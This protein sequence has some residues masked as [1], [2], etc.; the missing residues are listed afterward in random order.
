MTRGSRAAGGACEPLTWLNVTSREPQNLFIA[1]DEI[2]RQ[3]TIE[4]ACQKGGTGRT[5]TLVNAGAEAARV[6]AKVLFMDLDPNRVLTE[7]HLGFDPEGVQTVEDLILTARDGSAADVLLEAPAPWQPRKDLDYEQGGAIPGTDGAIAFIPAS[8]SLGA[9]AEQIGT[10]A[11][12]SEE[13]LAR[14]LE[15]V[16]RH[17]D[18]VLLDTGPFATRLAWLA[19]EAAATTICTFTPEDGPVK[20]LQNQIALMQEYANMKRRLPLRFGGAI[21]TKFDNRYQRQH[22]DG[23]DK[24]AAVLRDVEVD[25]IT[26]VVQMSPSV[27]GGSS[28]DAGAALWPELIEQRAVVLKWNS[29]RSP[30]VGGVQSG[31]DAAGFADKQEAA[32][33][34]LSLRPYTRVAMRLLQGVGAPSFEK[35]STWLADNASEV[36]RDDTHDSHEADGKVD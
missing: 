8:L 25:D 32:R 14:A 27:H 22:V 29:K 3:R 20:G 6:G 5:T 36:F 2:D 23:L 19:L 26:R 7:T 33:A 15:G 1:T 13:R 18:L 16:A 28:W 12:A 11:A 31:A 17:F 30:L 4:F 24:A 21:C 35:A 9:A 34:A 10:T